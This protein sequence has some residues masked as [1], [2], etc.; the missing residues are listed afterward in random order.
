MADRVVVLGGGA[1]AEAFVAALRRLDEQVSITLVERRL[2][3][4]ECTFWACMPTKTLLRSPE[5]RA[6]AGRAP[7]AAAGT[8]DVAQVFE[9]RDRVVD[10]LD[11]T[12]HVEWLEERR[13][14]V[15][16]GDGRVTAPGVLAVDGREL[17]YDT[18]VVATGSDPAVPP[19]AGLD[20]VA[21]WTN[22]EAATASEVPASLLVLGPG[23]VGCE[24]AQF[25]A[26]AGARV[27]LIGPDDRILPREDA[28]AALLL[29]ER[30]AEDGI[31]LRL[32]VHAVRAEAAGAGI[33]LHLS[34]GAEVEGAR[35]LV[36]TGRRPNAEGIGLESAGVRLAREGVEVDES[37]RAA[38]GVWAIGDVVAGAPLFTHVGK[39]HGRVAA[40]A[41]AGRAARADLR[42]VPR[43]LFTDPQVASVGTVDG[44]GVV[45][46]RWEVNRVSR[47][48]TYERPK[49]K[50][51]LKVLADPERR[52][53]VGAVAAGPEAGEWLG[54]LTLAIRAEVRVD[55]LRDVIQPFPTFSEVVYFAVRELPL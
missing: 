23:P 14:D 13:V 46:G 31:E 18:L 22:H 2:I 5:L 52:V 42:A 28:E 39:Y 36:A 26:R 17:R 45:E 55:V 1:A 51:F 8:L 47:S 16:R 41:I 7:G 4:G 50:G 33:R 20:E 30:L 9:W 54:Q 40:A 43:V 29:Q 21:Y 53:L 24:L 34:D 49:R 35:L 32:G 27:T 44:D 10:A 15:V 3:G 12:G 19:L 37:L 38:D 11:D 25:Y 6:E 48:S